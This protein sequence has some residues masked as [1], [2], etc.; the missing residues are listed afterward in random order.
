MAA[1]MNIWRVSFQFLNALLYF[2]F[3]HHSNSISWR[4]FYQLKCSRNKQFLK[5]IHW[6]NI[7]FVYF[8]L[9][10]IN[11]LFRSLWHLLQYISRPSSQSY[12]NICQNEEI[13]YFTDGF[14]F[15]YFNL[16]MDQIW[17]NPRL[18]HL[19]WYISFETSN[20]FQA[21]FVWVLTKSSP[22]KWKK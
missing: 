15:Y 14:F 19:K 6:S 10:M 17:L 8:E 3:I 21:W 18:N 22:K 4:H 12:F 16:F 20:R 7:R 5:D 2:F 9:F 1:T 11:C 13:F